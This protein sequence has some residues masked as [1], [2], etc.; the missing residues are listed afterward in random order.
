[1]L[2]NAAA[3]LMAGGKARDLKEG[4]A[5]AAHS[6]DSRAAQ[7]TLERLVTLSHELAQPA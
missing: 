5:L 7:A 4:V 1:V 3:A 6:I 2:M